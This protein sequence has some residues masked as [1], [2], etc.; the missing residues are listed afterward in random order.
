MFKLFARK[1]DSHLFKPVL[2]EIEESPLN[3][4]GRTIFWLIL[5]TI[6][7]FS[8][9]LY[10]GQID[11]VVAARGRV[12]PN[13]RLKYIQ[14]LNTGVIRRINC[15]PG[16]HIK[17]G[18]LLVEIDP[19]TTDPEL[20]QLNKNLLFQQIESERIES[21]LNQAEFKPDTTKYNADLLTLQTKIY[22]TVKQSLSQ[23]LQ[24]KEKEIQKIEEQ[25]KGVE[26]EREKSSTLLIINSVK[27]KRLEKVRDIIAY[28]K[29]EQVNNEIIVLKNQLKSL[30]FKTNELGLQKIQ[31]QKEISYIQTKFKEALLKEQSEKIKAINDLKEQISKIKFINKKQ[32]IVSPIDGYVVELFIHTVGGVVTPA[33]KLISIVPSN[34][35]FV[36]EASVMNQDIGFVK[37]D[38]PVSIK[39]D[40]FSF[41]KYGMLNGVVSQI[42]KDSIIDEKL[43]PIYKVYVKPL[44]L[45]LMVENK[46]VKISSGLTVTSEIKVGKRRIIEFFVYPLIKYLD[47][48]MS[49][50]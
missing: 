32:R 21:L 45:E 50:R 49:V 33:Q 36:I 34:S 28:E 47:E 16:D 39:I 20:N 40:T 41:Q 42:S 48:G 31:L 35:S 3:P 44:E 27:K 22:N 10:I 12:I 43:G 2:V 30:E 5:L 14:P 37:P 1:D 11:V 25:L 17:K 29:Y 26:T 24:S 7:F 46:P 6:L 15:Q 4:L 13:A 23:E 8:V 19:S 9:W 38:M 18:D